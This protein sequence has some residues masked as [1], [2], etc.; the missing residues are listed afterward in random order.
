MTEQEWLACADSTAMLELLQGKASDRKLRLFAVA[1]CRTAGEM[2][3]DELTR[4]ALLLAELAAD[5]QAK[6]RE[7]RAVLRKIRPQ[8][9]TQYGVFLCGGCGGPGSTY[10]AMAATAALGPDLTFTWYMG[11]TPSETHTAWE[12]VAR[13]RA[14]TAKEAAQ[15]KRWQEWEATATDSEDEPDD[16]WYEET[17]DACYAAWDRELAA[18]RVAFCPLLRDLAGPVPFRPVSFCSAW[19]TPIARALAQGI[20]EDQ[21]FDRLPIL[22]DALEEAGCDNADVLD[23]LRGPGPHVRGCWALDLLVRNE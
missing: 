6:P 15:E 3:P 7:V 18:A 11:N 10:A 8:V 1:C 17:Q 13:A 4:R 5:G 21:A 22:A 12:C 2:L 16:A 20:Y 23:H 14:Q 9:N 19:H